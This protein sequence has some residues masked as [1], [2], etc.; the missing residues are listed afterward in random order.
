MT[1]NIPTLPRP[2]PMPREEAPTPIPRRSSLEELRAGE[3]PYVAAID[4]LRVEVLKLSAKL[5]ELDAR[6]SKTDLAQEAKLSEH[7]LRLVRIE[8][9]SKAAASGTD[10]LVHALTGKLSPKLLGAFVALGTLVQILLQAYR[11][12]HGG[13]P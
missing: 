3:D 7:E 4:E 9:A 10:T 13:T 5:P 6:T 11:Q 2:A 8:T 1:D 12:L